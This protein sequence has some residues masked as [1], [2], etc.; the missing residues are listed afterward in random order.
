MKN[1]VFPFIAIIFL[2]AQPLSAQSK[3]EL[4]K[5]QELIEYTETKTLIES[6]EFMFEARSCN[7]QKGRRIDLT[8]N[9]GY[10]EINGSTVTSDMP[11]FGF[12]QLSSYESSGGF[13]FVNEDVDFKID[14]NDKKRKI[15]IKFK[16]KGEAEIIDIFLLIYGSG[17]TSMN[18]TSSHRD[19]ITYRG[20]IKPLK[21]EK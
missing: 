10:L 3:K 6:G 12:S 5:E 9:S 16:A 7:T 14:F 19:F 2:I 21:K 13:N 11:Y 18:A 1:L 17:T 15:T 20:E 4:K 8:T